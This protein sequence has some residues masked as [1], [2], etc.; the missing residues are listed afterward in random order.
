MGSTY[1]LV[2]DL[3]REVKPTQC[4]LGLGHRR[5]GL[6]ATRELLVQRCYSKARRK[7]EGEVCKV[8]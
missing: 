5:K 3:A 1:D 7:S 2:S 4:F 6:T 8:S